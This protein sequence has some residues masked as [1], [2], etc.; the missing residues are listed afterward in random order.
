MNFCVTGQAL[1]KI[2]LEKLLFPHLQMGEIMLSKVKQFVPELEFK[3]GSAGIPS[4]SFHYPSF[5][6]EKAKDLRTMRVNSWRNYKDDLLLISC[7]SMTPFQ[8]VLLPLK[9]TNVFA[10]NIGL[11]ILK[12]ECQV[13]QFN[14]SIFIQG[15]H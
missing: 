2:L 9:T 1:D 4:H 15:T 5:F 11:A 10:V 12:Q 13:L 6:L 7:F 14:M 8:S 3:S